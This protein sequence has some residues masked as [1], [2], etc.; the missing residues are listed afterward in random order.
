MGLSPSTS[1]SDKDKLH[2]L[3]QLDRYREWHSLDERRYCLVCGKIITG[4][5]IQV[6][7]A[8]FGNG[9]LRL[10]CP[11]AQCNS[12]PMDWALPTD[13]IPAVGET[14]APNECNLAPMRA[15]D[16]GVERGL[17]SQSRNSLCIS[18]EH[19]NDWISKYCEPAGEW[20]LIV[21]RDRNKC[22]WHWTAP[23]AGKRTLA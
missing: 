23:S 6:A 13:E 12:T 22:Q 5:Q 20:A 2:T 19:S 15:D 1:M 4:R 18:S 3:Q 10:S 16:S 14:V 8:T 17:T 11:T 21:L 7:G 9:P